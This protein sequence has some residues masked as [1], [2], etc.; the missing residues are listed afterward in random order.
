[1]ELLDDGL[2]IVVENIRFTLI[3]RTTTYEKVSNV[4]YFIRFSIC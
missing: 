1:M 2:S 3:Y 4:K